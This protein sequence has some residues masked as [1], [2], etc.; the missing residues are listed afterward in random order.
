MPKKQKKTMPRARSKASSKQPPARLPV[1]SL[2]S[3]APEQ[4]SLVDAIKSGPRGQF[5]NEGPFAA[6]LH[7]PAYGV[8]AQKLGGHLRFNTCVPPRLSEFAILCTGQFWKAQYEWYAHAAIAA[9]QGV[10]EATIRDLKA[11]RAPKSAPR[12]EMAIYAFVKELYAA[13]RVSNATY[14]R[15]HKFLGDAGMVELVGIL[16]YYV[17]ISMT[18][19]VFRMPLPEGAALP[20]KEPGKS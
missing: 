15:V 20:F 5:N 3:L 2:D 9:K 19:D 1:L 11:G 7:A 6:F 14:A 17:L 8:L 13:R 4:Q 18:L 10:K 12:D 16:G